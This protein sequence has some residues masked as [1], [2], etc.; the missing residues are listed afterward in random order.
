VEVLCPATGKRLASVIGYRIGSHDYGVVENDPSGSWDPRA[1]A[2][3]GKMNVNTNPRLRIEL[4]GWWATDQL[5]LSYCPT[6][7]VMIF[8][9]DNSEPRKDPTHRS[10]GDAHPGYTATQPAVLATAVFRCTR[11]RRDHLIDAQHLGMAIFGRVEPTYRLDSRL[12]SSRP[13][14]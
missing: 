1:R 7:R 11:C 10:G 12:T 8:Q 9:L 14:R 3:A 4:D 13:I 6:C 2:D 5:N